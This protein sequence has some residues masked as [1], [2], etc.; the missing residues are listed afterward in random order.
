MNGITEPIIVSGMSIPEAQNECV[1]AAL[2]YYSSYVLFVEDDMYFPADTLKQ[3]IK[4][5]AAITCVDY[6]MD[7]GYSTITRWGEKILWC[8][9][10]CTLV[11]RGV[12]TAMKNNWFE[13]D[14]SY[15]INDNPFRLE[16]IENPNKYGGHDINFCMK[17]KDLGFEI[18]Q[19]VGIEAQHLRCKNLTKSQY[20]TGAWDIEAL[21]S[22]SKWQQY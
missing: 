9:F 18:K 1:K 13:T 16:R 11:K 12:L 22:V 14:Y 5:D 21:P 17:A 19:V 20:N 15:K 8:G 4:V 6:P 10:G 7:N 3:M 2:N